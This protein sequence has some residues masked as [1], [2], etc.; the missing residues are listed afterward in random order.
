M[1][2]RKERSRQ[3]GIRGAVVELGGRK[4]RERT[5]MVL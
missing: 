3:G 4:K 1:L 5:T 2:K